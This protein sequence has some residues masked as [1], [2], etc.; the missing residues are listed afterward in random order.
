VGQTFSETAAAAGLMRSNFKEQ[1]GKRNLNRRGGRI[2]KRTKEPC[3]LFALF[4][5]FEVT[6]KG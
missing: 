5:A 3:S 1:R 2:K 6:F 4:C